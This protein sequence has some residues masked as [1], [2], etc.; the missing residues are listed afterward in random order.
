M[1]DASKPAELPVIIKAYDLVR[2]ITHRAA[3]FPRDHKFVLGDRMLNT[4]W[5]VFEAL[6]NARYLKDKRS[7]LSRA[8]LAL[9]RLRF[10]VRYCY[11]EKLMSE[12]QYAFVS[13][14]IYE[15]G[16]MTGGWM[17]SLK[18]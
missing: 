6:I 5:D 14:L 9:E 18:P 7:E 10:Q 13:R 8:N 11:D 17:K 4:C 12:K 16:S 15:T 2:E 3:K 1:T